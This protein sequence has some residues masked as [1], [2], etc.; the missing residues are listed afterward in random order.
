MMQYRK[1]VNKYTDIIPTSH[2]YTHF[3]QF[4]WL[5]E[6]FY[7]SINS[8]SKNL[9]TILCVPALKIHNYFNSAEFFT[10]R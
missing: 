6:K 8:A 7:T 4:D 9:G 3:E 2:D 10:H 1:K 5:K